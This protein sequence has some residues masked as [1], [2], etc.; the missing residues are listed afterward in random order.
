M[1]VFGTTSQRLKQI[2]PKRSS[3]AT[4]CKVYPRHAYQVSAFSKINHETTFVGHGR[5]GSPS[6]CSTAT[7]PSSTCATIPL[8]MTALLLHSHLPSSTCCNFQ[9]IV[10]QDTHKRF[11][12][13]FHIYQY[14]YLDILLMSRQQLPQLLLLSL[15]LKSSHKRSWWSM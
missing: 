11:I 13:T 14:H 1:D 9:D 2:L 10:H 8:S 6:S 15:D 3:E 4:K 5:E 7:V 12:I